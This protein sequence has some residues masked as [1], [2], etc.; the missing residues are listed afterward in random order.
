M[1]KAV[2]DYLIKTASKKLSTEYDHDCN[3]QCEDCIDAKEAFTVKDVYDMGKRD[4]KIKFARKLLD[5]FD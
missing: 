2:L 3:G 4:G 1:E 5:K